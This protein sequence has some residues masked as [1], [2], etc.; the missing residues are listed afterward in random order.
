M[1]WLIV[2]P[3]LL[4]LLFGPS[5]VRG[6]LSAALFFYLVWRAWPAIVE[7]LGRLRLPTPGRPRRNRRGGV[8]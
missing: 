3:G 2:S 8:L 1:K 7:D 6:V 5:P 4:L